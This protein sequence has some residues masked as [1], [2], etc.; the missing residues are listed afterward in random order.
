MRRYVEAAGDIVACN[1]G[2]V[3]VS[4]MCKEGSATLQGAG[5]KCSAPAG[6]V[7]L[8]LRK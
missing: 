4:A 3:L 1:D 2:E 8:C 6:A 7:G 5:A